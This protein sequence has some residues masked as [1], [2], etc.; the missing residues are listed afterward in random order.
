MK[1]VVS[2]I[3]INNVSRFLT[4]MSSRSQIKSI[5]INLTTIMPQFPVCKMSN[6]T[7]TTYNQP[8]VLRYVNTCIQLYLFWYTEPTAAGILRRSYHHALINHTFQ[9]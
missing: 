5:A 4:A 9:Q 8:Y 3:Y 6:C 1:S 2:L 7:L